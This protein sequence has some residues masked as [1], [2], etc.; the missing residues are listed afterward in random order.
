MWG[1]YPPTFELAI[2]NNNA[3]EL[4]YYLNPFSQGRGID[5]LN[6]AA[7]LGFN[8]RD[9]DKCLTICQPIQERF[10]RVNTE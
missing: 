4:A 1:E 8:K 7:L 5:A 9:V 10:K 3:V 2:E 6:A